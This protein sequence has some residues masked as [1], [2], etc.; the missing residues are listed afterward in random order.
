MNHMNNV[1]K[2]KYHSVWMPIGCSI[3][4]KIPLFNE[5]LDEVEDS[6]K[7]HIKFVIFFQEGLA[8]ERIDKFMSALRDKFPTQ[9]VEINK[10][11]TEQE[12]SEIIAFCREFNG[13]E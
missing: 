1:E 7:S 9:E 6:R 4:L 12:M 10:G 11:V 13:D 5:W 3:D 8:D 2:F